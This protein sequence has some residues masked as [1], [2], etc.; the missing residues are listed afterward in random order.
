MKFAALET[1]TL[2][3][4][5]TNFGCEAFKGCKELHNVYFNGSL[6]EWLSIDMVGARFSQPLSNGANLY[7]NGTL[8]TEITVPVDSEIKSGAFE[9]CISLKKVN[10]PQFVK[11]IGFVA[12][13][14][15][16]Y[17]EDVCIENGVSFI[18]S[19]AFSGCKAL[20]SIQIPASVI[21]ISQRT[22]MG[23]VSLASVDLP[24]TIVAVE[25][26]LFQECIALEEINIPEN[27]QKIEQYAFC[28]CVALK[29]VNI[30]KNTKEIASN[31]FSGCSQLTIKTSK[32]SFAETFA[33][34][35]GYAIKLG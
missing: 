16:A 34:K 20:C 19:L 23:C 27:I 24:S 1:I 35:K 8:M 7:I 31:A 2:P 22:F 28:E 25:E 30:S 15:C 4:S 5:I 33:N 12:F 32:G 18:D 13:C 21:K 9:G 17:L 10:I 11:S 26:G 6:S 29:N 3:N 14:N